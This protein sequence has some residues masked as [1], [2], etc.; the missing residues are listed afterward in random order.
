[1]RE[2]Y[3]ILLRPLLTE[4]SNALKDSFNQYTFKVALDCNKAEIKRAVEEL[5]KVEVKAVRTSV[6]PGKTRRMG[7]YQGVRSDWKKAIVTLKK[8]HKID[9]TQEAA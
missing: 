4:R 1:M 6:V 3:S 2:I 9:M 7:R 8:G 5:F